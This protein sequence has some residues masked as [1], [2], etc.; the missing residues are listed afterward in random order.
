M[1]ADTAEQKRERLDRAFAARDAR[2]AREGRPARERSFSEEGAVIACM[3]TFLLQ[4]TFGTH[5]RIAEGQIKA[6]IDAARL[7][8][9]TIEG[10]RRAPS[11][12]VATPRA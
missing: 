1:P 6:A 7:I 2:W 3:A 10:E 12:Q 8:I 5:G 4:P 11:S 9:K